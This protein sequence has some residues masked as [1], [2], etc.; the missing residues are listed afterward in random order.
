MSLSP[1]TLSKHLTEQQA[2]VPAVT[3]E[4]CLVINQLAVAGKIIGRELGEAALIGELG[5]TGETNVQGEAVQK[6]DELANTVFV[7]MFEGQACLVKAVVSEEM[8]KPWEV[9]GLTGDCP[10]ARYVLFLDPLD[11]SSNLDVNL[12]VGSIFSIHRWSARSQSDL[13]AQ[14]LKRGAEQIAAGYMLYGP[15]TLLVYTCGAG[16][17]Q[18]TLDRRIGE[19]ILSGS[20]LT[21]PPQ[22]K[23]Y[24]VND[25][26]YAK[27]PHEVR[28]FV[29]YLRDQDGTSGRAYATRYSGCLVA[30]VHRF[31]SGG[32][33]YLYPGEKSKPEGKLRLMYEAAPLGFV[34]EQAGGLA[35]TGKERVG[36]VIP[37]VV[38]ERVP[39]II[40][41]RD[42]VCMAEAFIQ[43][44][45]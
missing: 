12:T 45:R 4:L 23:V 40:G 11:G 17:Y 32:G 20:R 41:S 30:D 14:L 1:T 5:V 22:G 3:P 36:Q 28:R 43:G 13:S 35:S 21:M 38:H 8:E 19:F 26:N 42:E 44:T 31:L 7:Q 9:G 18:F 6:L 10:D 16:V 15:S 37:K 25:G 33:V 29:D 2:I 27:W 24:S 39:L 34:I